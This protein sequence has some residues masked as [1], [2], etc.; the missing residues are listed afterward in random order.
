MTTALKRF[1]RQMY[2]TWQLNDAR[3]IAQR[4]ADEHQEPVAIIQRD[5]LWDGER[6]YTGHDCATYGWALANRIDTA[7][8]VAWVEPTGAVPTIRT[9]TRY[10]LDSAGQA[11]A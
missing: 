9:M 10:I 8:I 4:M 5:D 7:L 11:V 6:T 1:P 3:S 2:P